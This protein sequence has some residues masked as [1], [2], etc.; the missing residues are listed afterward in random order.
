MDKINVAI[1]VAEMRDKRNLSKSVCHSRLDSPRRSRRRSLG[2][3][4]RKIQYWI[5]ASRLGEALRR[6][7]VAGMTGT[8]YDGKF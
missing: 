6:S 2:R 8:I 3:E 7:L 4:S 5:P 1:G